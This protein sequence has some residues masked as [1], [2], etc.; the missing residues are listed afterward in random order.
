M[1]VAVIV[2]DFVTMV[3]MVEAELVAVVT[4]RY[5]QNHQYYHYRVSIYSMGIIMYTKYGNV[6]IYLVLPM[7]SM[8]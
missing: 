6:S 5:H 3:V 8:Y 4:C 7:T 2:F 1:V